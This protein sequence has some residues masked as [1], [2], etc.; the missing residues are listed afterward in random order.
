MIIF[1]LHILEQTACFA[2]YQYQSHLDTT[3]LSYFQLIVLHPDQR[4]P[5]LTFALAPQYLI[6]PQT[7]LTRQQSYHLIAAAQTPVAKTLQC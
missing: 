1:S 7:L 2:L 5:S 6:D 4:V 3:L